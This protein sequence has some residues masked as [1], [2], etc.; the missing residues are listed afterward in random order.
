MTFIK[1][2]YF[3]YLSHY[4]STAAIN[5]DGGDIR[6]FS[7]T[8]TMERIHKR[9]TNCQKTFQNIVINHH[10]RYTGY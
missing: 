9:L 10:N 1:Y 2:L 6:N 8:K 5:A 7:F 4:N 3:S